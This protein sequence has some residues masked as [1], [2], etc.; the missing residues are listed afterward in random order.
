[1]LIN[2]HTLLFAEPDQVVSHQNKQS[3][4]RIISCSFFWYP[5]REKLKSTDDGKTKV[6]IGSLDPD[7][8]VGE[9]VL[10]AYENARYLM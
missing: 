3:L 9:I 7:C 4:I 1:M 2:Q 8:E 5:K 6:M 10:E